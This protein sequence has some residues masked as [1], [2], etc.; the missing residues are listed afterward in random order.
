MRFPSALFAVLLFASPAPAA[1]AAAGTP[2]P[3][4]SGDWGRDEA[5]LRANANAIAAKLLIAAKEGV[6]VDGKR[7]AYAR[8]PDFVIDLRSVVIGGSPAAAFS[9]GIGM[10]SPGKGIGGVDHSANDL[11]YTTN[12]LYTMADQPEAAMFLAHE[13]GHLALGHAAKLEKAKKEI[14]DKLFTEWEQTNTVPDGEASAV[15]VNRFFRDSGGKIQ[16]ALNP[17]QQPME[18]EADKYGRALAVKAGYPGEASVSSF[19]RAQDWLWAL[20][21]DL[22]DPNHAG[23][24][25]DRAA[26][27]AKW[28]DDQKA[29]KERSA[30]A[31]RRSKCAAEGTSCQ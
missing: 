5:A 19:R 10:N 2:T 15:T 28:L 1:P 26:K 14:I 18:D 20:K 8:L 30:T 27:N 13:I 29:A 4:S 11:V 25:A 21:L 24:V 23:S 6:E 9:A 16:A 17:I 7:V 3:H 22:D 31:L 12:A